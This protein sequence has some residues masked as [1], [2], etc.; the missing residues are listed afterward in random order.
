MNPVANNLEAAGLESV[1]AEQSVLGGLLLHNAALDRISSLRPDH[2]SRQ[3][4]RAIFGELQAQIS[5]GRTA[6]VITIFERLQA[7]GLDDKVGGLM[8]LNSLVQSV[9]GAS[10]IGR[11]AAIVIERSK[12][13]ALR[14]VGA[15]AVGIAQDASTP[16]D[17]RIERMAAELATLM[18][19][20]A[21]REP[22]ALAHALAGHMGVLE[23]R[24]EG[25]VRVI[26]TGLA[27][28]DGLFGGGLRPGNL[29]IF[30]ARP[31]MGKTAMGLTI[32]LHM[33]K[34]TPIGFL[35]MEMSAEELNDR[36]LACLGRVDLADV[37]RPAEAKGDFWDRVTEA[38]QS[39]SDLSLFVDDQGGLNLAQVRMKVR[40]LK[41]QHGVGV[42]VVDYLQLMQSRD[43]TQ[44]R[45]YALEEICRGLKALAKELDIVV[46]ALAQVNRRVGDGLPG[47]SDLKDSGAIEQDAD[48]VMF[49]HRPIQLNPTLGKEFAPYAR[50]FVAKNRQGRTGVIPL[51]YA[52]AQTRFF[53]WSGPEPQLPAAPRRTEL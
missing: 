36:T 32:A 42:V 16:V 52:G 2:F 18:Q 10:N 13:R 19:A 5:A 53:D 45:A 48:A 28:V 46:I 26:P 41:R 49:I 9:P 21:S 50:M 37:Q 7:A 3:E 23:A 14:D 11:Y 35:S 33:A 51:S 43:D 1:E 47:L 22:V 17:Q 31:S 30:G 4:H 12:A 6:D 34:T 15:R 27:A 8:Y 25:R 38:A 24:Y 29:V 39:A 20:T 40:S 44:H